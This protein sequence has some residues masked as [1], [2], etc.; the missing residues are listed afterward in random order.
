[1]RVMDTAS[2]A[3]LQATMPMHRQM[4]ANM[5]AQMNNEMRRMNMTGDARWTALMDSLRQ[6]L[7]RMPEMNAQQ[8]KAF[9]PEH[10]SRVARLMQGHR[11]MMKNMKM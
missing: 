7:I 3:T 5:I 1:M 10:H 11:D 4:A 6:D 2:A 8:L 9:M